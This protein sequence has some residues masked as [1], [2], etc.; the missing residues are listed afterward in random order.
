[1]VSPLLSSVPPAPPQLFSNKAQVPTALGDFR[2]QKTQQEAASLLRSAKT[3]GQIAI[4]ISNFFPLFFYRFPRNVSPFSFLT[5]L[6]SEG[7][8][9][10]FKAISRRLFL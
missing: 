3:L 8:I 6:F 7:F 9:L 4:S 5:C 1:M 10:D 2:N